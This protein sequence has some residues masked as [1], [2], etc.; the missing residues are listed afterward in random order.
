MSQVRVHRRHLVALK[1]CAK[2]T[3]AFFNRH[4]WDYHDFLRHGLPV[5]VWRATGDAMAIRAAEVAE[6]EAVRGR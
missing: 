3:R 5:E 6:E 2:G 4:G 1:Y